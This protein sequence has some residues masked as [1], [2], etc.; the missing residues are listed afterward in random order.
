MLLVLVAVASLIS[1][2]S[3]QILESKDLFL[4]DIKISKPGDLTVYIDD[5]SGFNAQQRVIKDLTPHSAGEW[6]PTQIEL[7]D[8]KTI[9][10][11]RIDPLSSNQNDVVFA[12]IRNVCFETNRRTFHSFFDQIIAV[13]MDQIYANHFIKVL[14]RSAE[15]IE[16]IILEHATDPYLL[17]ILED[18]G[19]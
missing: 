9:K 8:I 1:F 11:L 12:A 2:V 10:Q 6:V 17:V 3:V 13:D 14:S 19:A 7:D 16:F 4:F 15:E 18:S 5:G